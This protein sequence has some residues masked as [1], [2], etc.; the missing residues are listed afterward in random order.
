MTFQTSEQAKQGYIEKMGEP[1]G[2]QFH[3][4][5]Q[6]VIFLHRK[7]MQYV[8]LFG[9]KPTRIALMNRAAPVFFRTLQD[10]SWDDLLLHIARLTDPSEMGKFK[11]LTLQNLPGLITDQKLKEKIDPLLK[12]ALEQSEFCREWRNKLVAHRDLDTAIN[13]TAGQISG[14]SREQVAA[15]LKTIAEMLNAIELHFKDGSTFYDFDE[16]RGGAKQLLL[17]LDDG[18]KHHDERRARI[19]SRKATPD[20]LAERDI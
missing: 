7:W 20:D 18:V 12:K 3:E 16:D 9:T 1:L 15:L 8:A 17:F 19:A 4:L 6:E 14:G 5:R 10:G 2:I 13:G 11:N